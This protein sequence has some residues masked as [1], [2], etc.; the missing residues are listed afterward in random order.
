MLH[1]VRRQ[2]KKCSE[3]GP[4]R[5]CSGLEQYQY[6]FRYYLYFLSVCVCVSVCLSVRVKP[7][8]IQS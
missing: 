5:R 2:N 8:K 1:L 3:T 4:K 7:E 6:P